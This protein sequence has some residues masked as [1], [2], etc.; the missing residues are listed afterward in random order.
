MRIII[1]TIILYFG[2]YLFTNVAV[3]EDVREALREK[4]RFLSQR[5]AII[6]KNIANADTPGFKALDLSAP[7][8]KNSGSGSLKL[9]TTSPK[10]LTGNNG[11]SSNFK[12]FRQK[13]AYET[14]PNGNNVSIEE[15]TTKLAGN[16]IEHQTTKSALKKISNLM[17]MAI[18]Q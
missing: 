17:S 1:L 8:G 16:N 6:S 11:S 14:A 9:A 5:Q 2:V 3:A 7:Q 13:T 4:M 10:H 18:G 12:V 15:Q